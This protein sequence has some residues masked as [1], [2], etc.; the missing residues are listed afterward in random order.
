MEELIKNL[1]NC[2][3]NSE[4]SDSDMNLLRSSVVA[5]YDGT[6]SEQQ[7][8]LYFALVRMGGE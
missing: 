5:H 6:A 1:K 7:E 2:N 8:E 3:G 4:L